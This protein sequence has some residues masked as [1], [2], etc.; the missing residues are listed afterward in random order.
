MGIQ[1][2]QQPNADTFS[3]TSLNTLTSTSSTSSSSSYPSTSSP[4]PSS[5]STSLTISWWERLWKKTD[6][7]TSSS[8]H[9]ISADKRKQVYSVKHLVTKQT[10]SRDFSFHKE[11]KKVSTYPSQ[12]CH[13]CENGYLTRLSDHSLFCGRDCHTAWNIRM[14]EV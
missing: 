11:K 3:Y 14:E 9:W 7:H 5:R 13:N 2:I 10:K 1:E 4:S 8:P 6:R 12:R